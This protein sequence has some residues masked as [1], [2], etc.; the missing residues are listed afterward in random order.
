[1][2][3]LE[4]R[5]RNF[6]SYFGEEVSFDLRGRSLVGI[7]GP[8][9]SGKSSVLDAVAFALYGKTPAGGSGTKAL[10][11][12]RATDGGVMLRFEVDG[13]IWEAVR[14]LRARGQSQHAL[15]RYEADT[16]DAEPVEKLT[17]EAEVNERVAAMLGLDFDAFGRSI[18]LAQGRFAEFL[19]ARPAER[20]AV[21]KG[22]FGLDRIDA[23]RDTAKRRGAE[24]SAE[25]GKVA[26]RTE[27]L[28]RVAERLAAN[29]AVLG[30]VEERLEKLRKAE[31]VL[32]D[33]DRR[34]A[35]AEAESKSAQ[36]RLDELAKHVERLPDP[37]VTHRLIDDAAAATKRRRELATTLDAAQSAL[38]E[39]EEAAASLRDGG[40]VA[41]IEE[42][43]RLVA[44]AEPLRRNV[45]ESARR[46]ETL[47]RRLGEA[48]VRRTE[49]QSTVGD[50]EEALETADGRMRDIDAALRAAEQTHHDA[51]HRNMALTLRDGLEQG[52]PCP[53][54]E[55]QVAT[56][57]PRAVGG[58]VDAAAAALQTAKRDRIAAERSRSDAAA[59]VTAARAGLEAAVV[60]VDSLTSELDQATAAHEA[61]R[62]EVEQTNVRLEELLGVGDPIELL[63]LRKRELTAATEAVTEARRKVEQARSRHDQAIV[64]EQGV[65]KELSALRVS[66]VEMA[67]RLGSTIDATDDAETLGR[68]AALLH[69]AWS[70]ETASLKGTLEIAGRE[71]DTFRKERHG[72]LEELDIEGPFTAALATAQARAEHL[73]ADIERDATEVASGDELLAERDRL[74]SAAARYDRIASDLTDSRFVR[75]LLDEERERLAELGSDH[76]QRLSSGRYRFTDD[77]TFAIVDLTAADAVRKASSLSGGETFLA[78]LALALSLSEMVT[79]TGGRLDAFFLDEGFGSL[80][81]EHLDL[82]ME[83]IEALVADDAS[84][85]VVVVSHV[86]ELR[87]RIEDLIELDRDPTTG[88]TRVL[89]S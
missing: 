73:G 87:H 65:G 26:V 32:V 81:P 34:I 13:E 50:S 6:R 5:L 28:D 15:Y 55:Q 11:H 80:D 70:E 61:A 18:L 4:L 19:R 12:Q 82:A 52:S 77:G 40:E 35:A 1:M 62:S 23:M 7:V 64:D 78:S 67:A 54:C 57:P 79:R 84:R 33:I 46:R 38:T 71:L 68:A 56:L 86:P 63:D 74:A 39:A 76:F 3:P 48:A 88:D 22:V 75:F 49:A 47:E 83:G 69:T 9:G 21:L 51:Q 89:R 36:A 14:S 43:A 2:R 60:L 17:L 37:A 8:I 27:Q 29:R 31:P 66:L 25:L 16:A 44:A 85:L 20:D 24:T 58:D 10:I 72:L 41:T 45:E 42:A 30:S 53:V 59:A